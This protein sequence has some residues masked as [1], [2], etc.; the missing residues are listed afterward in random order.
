MPIAT[1]PVF[2]TLP[3]RSMPFT[4]S[5]VWKTIGPEMLSGAEALQQPWTYP[6]YKYVMNSGYLRTGAAFQDYQTLI[7]FFNSG[8]GRNSPFQFDDPTDDTAPTNQ[9][10]G[11]GDGVTTSFQLVRAFG[12]YVEPVFAVNTITNIN[13]NG[14]PMTPAGNWTVSPKGVVTFNVA[15]SNGTVLTWNGTFLWFCRWDADNID[16]SMIRAVLVAGDPAGMLWQLQQ[17][18]FTTIK[19]GS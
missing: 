12:G 6:R 7:G 13:L 16:L 1:N 17:M 18:S 19:F 14:V 4:R 2:P 8:G 5:P 11:T 3:S 10:F 9:L 15:P